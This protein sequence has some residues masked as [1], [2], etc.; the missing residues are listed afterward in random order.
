MFSCLFGEALAEIP[1]LLEVMLPEMDKEKKKP[2]F[3]L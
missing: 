2:L 1:A 3:E